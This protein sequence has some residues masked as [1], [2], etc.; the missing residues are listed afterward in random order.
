MRLGLVCM[1][2]G[3]SMRKG[4]TGINAIN[5]MGDIEFVKKVHS[6]TM[7]NIEYTK[8]CIKWCIDNKTG[9]YRVS[10]NIIPYYEFWNW[11]EFSDI[12]N[13]LSDIYELANTNDIRLTIHP[14]QFTVINSEKSHVVNNSIKILQHH[15]VLSC[16]MGIG[17]IIIH[18]G[19]AKGDYKKRFVD[20]C[21]MLDIRIKN[22]I[23][24]ENCH[25]VGISD[26]LD[27][28]RKTGLKPCLDVHHDRIKPSEN[29]VFYYVSEIKEMWNTKPLGHIS[30][31]KCSNLDISHNDYIVESDVKKFIKFFNMFDLEIEAKKKDLAIIRLKGMIKKEVI[32]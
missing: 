3:Q 28:C 25:S 4:V 17:D 13:G 5:N 31:G 16:Y 14:D 6:A 8:K 2:H 20:G 15:Y 9:M 21:N 18:T 12:R 30:S 26:V 23:V 1:L 29:D 7:H 10:S 24:L 19:S 27:I 22:K 32:L 11:V